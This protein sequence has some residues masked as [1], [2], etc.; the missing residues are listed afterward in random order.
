MG[1]G[2]RISGGKIVWLTYGPPTVFGDGGPANLIQAICETEKDGRLYHHEVRIGNTNEK[3]K[4][5]DWLD[6]SA[7][8]DRNRLS[9]ELWWY[10]ALGDKWDEPIKIWLYSAHDISGRG[11]KGDRPWVV[12]SHDGVHTLDGR[13]LTLGF[14]GENP[15]NI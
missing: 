10:R 3:L 14:R 8:Y 1:I 9:S 11:W 13:D 15:R 12:G 2:N 6:W 7:Q 5:G 4:V